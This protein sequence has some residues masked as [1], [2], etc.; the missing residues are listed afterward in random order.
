M[1]ISSPISC[2]CW[3]PACGSAYSAAASCCARLRL[4]K[5]ALID[6][7]ATTRLTVREPLPKLQPFRQKISGR[8]PKILRLQPGAP[9]DPRQHSRPELLA[10][11]EGKHAIGRSSRAGA[12]RPPA[13]LDGVARCQF[14]KM[15]AG[16]NWG[17]QSDRGH[18][19]ICAK[20]YASAGRPTRR[21]HRVGELSFAARHRGDGVA[22]TPAIRASESESGIATDTRRSAQCNLVAPSTFVLPSAQISRGPLTASAMRFPLRREPPL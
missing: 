6:G 19:T 18:R 9:G 13:S 10:V 14:P 17:S 5:I 12:R 1:H 16:R 3:P 4:A 20:S 7:R 2:T 8:P 11:V 21:L 22:P 15:R